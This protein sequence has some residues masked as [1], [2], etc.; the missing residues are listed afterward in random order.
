MKA[1][2]RMTARLPDRLIRTV[3]ETISGLPPGSNPQIGALGELASALLGE[4]DSDEPWHQGY[5]LAQLL[6]EEL[7]APAGRIDPEDILR[8]WGI[9]IR[10]IDL[11]GAGIDAVAVWA[12][13]RKPTI[14]VNRDGPRAQMPT[15]VRSTLAHEICH[16]LIDRDGA[17]PA[18]EVLGGR[19]PARIEARANAFAAELLLPRSAVASYLRDELAFVNQ[20]DARDSVIEGAVSDF[21]VEYEV[22][23]ELSAWQIRNSGAIE[24]ADESVL[25][26]KLNSIH[27]PL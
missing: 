7:N 22:S 17:L 24:E 27:S 13:G 18:A 5:R 20:R 8:S 10:G 26:P 19:V 16:L 23:H 11:P 21:A 12:A 1:A 4:A 25:L 6:R 14:F 15:G 9:V 3:L 2:A